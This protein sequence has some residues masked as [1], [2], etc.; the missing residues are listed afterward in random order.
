MIVTDAAASF[1]L[2]ILSA[3]NDASCNGVKIFSSGEILVACEGIGIF[4]FFWKRSDARLQDNFKWIKQASKGCV[5]AVYHFMN[6][7]HLHD[8][9]S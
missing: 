1:S 6:L 3:L 4:E 5:R 9:F 2:A 7:V 8:K